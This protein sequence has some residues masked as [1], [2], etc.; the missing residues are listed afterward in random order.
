MGYQS[1]SD[2]TAYLDWSALR[3]MSE[4]EFEKI[5]RGPLASVA[6]E[7]AWGTTTISYVAPAGVLNSGLANEG[8]NSV[9]N[10]RANYQQLSGYVPVSINGATKVGFTATGS[11]GRASASAAYYGAMEMSGNIYEYTVNTKTG[12]SAYTGVLGDGE[13]STIAAVDGDSN[14]TNWPDNTGVIFRGGG[15]DGASGYSGDNSLSLRI[16][17]RNQGAPTS[18]TTRGASYGGRGVR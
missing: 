17:D 13:L 14:Q 11:S 10:G 9:T 18:S 4:L 12:G 2:F 16:S 6:G 8:Y 7:F 5:T 15:F 3:P 1:W